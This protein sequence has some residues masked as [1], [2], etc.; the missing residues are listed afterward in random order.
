[1]IDKTFHCYKCQRVYV[2]PTSCDHYM[3]DR[4]KS[5]ESQLKI[6]EDALR[7]YAILGNCMNT[8]KGYEP[9]YRKIMLND[10]ELVDGIKY[11]GKHARTAL[12]KLEKLKGEG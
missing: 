3:D 9:D 5:L 12:E 1:M 11:G 7:I 10:S 2:L 8:H 4:I 6:A